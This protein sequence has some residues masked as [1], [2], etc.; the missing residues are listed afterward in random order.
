MLVANVYF[1]ERT[2]KRT[3][4][5]AIRLPSNVEA[6]YNISNLMDARNFA[7]SNIGTI[8]RAA[9]MKTIM[10]GILFCTLL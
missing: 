10:I 3:L 4:R 6:R 8:I 1:N 9:N 7:R 5:S 2:N